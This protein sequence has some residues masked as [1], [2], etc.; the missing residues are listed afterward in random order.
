MAA[1]ADVPTSWVGIE[2]LPVHFAN[3]FGVAPAPNAIFLLFGS[4]IPL[5]DEALP[6]SAFAPI[7][8]IARMA[9]AP[10]A[11]PQLVEALQGAMATREASEGE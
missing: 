11:V 8:P 4:V 5:A 9:I 3:V 2:E 1:P 7:R 6:P 10:A